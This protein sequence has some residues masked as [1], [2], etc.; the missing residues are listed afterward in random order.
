VQVTLTPLETAGGLKMVVA[1]LDANRALVLES[2]QP[3]GN[4]TRLC[5][6]GVLVYTVDGTITFSGSPIRVLPAHP[7]TDT[8]GAKQQQCGPK[9]DAP[10]DLGA[11]ETSSLHDAATGVGVELVSSSGGSYVVRVSRLP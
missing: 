3:L 11:G 7:G 1:P 2:R 5:D 10:L 8:D 4:D 9:Y 6:K